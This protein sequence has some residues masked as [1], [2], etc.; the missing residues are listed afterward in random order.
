MTNQSEASA[1]SRRQSKQSSP[2]MAIQGLTLLEREQ[3]S[4][5]RQG[6]REGDRDV[7]ATSPASTGTEKRWATVT[8]SFH[9]GG[10]PSSVQSAEWITATV[11]SVFALQT[12]FQKPILE[13]H[14]RHQAHLSKTT[15]N[16]SPVRGTLQG[17]IN[18]K[19]EVCARSRDYSPVSLCSVQ[20]TPDARSS[21]GS[22]CSNDTASQVV[23]SRPWL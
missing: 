16:Q 4:R 21:I 14:H 17:T 8:A 9:S 19:R 13:A 7:E 3:R 23:S 10:R 20:S 18:V 2:C 11:T 22:F 15:A 5:Q 1:D 6:A 12:Y